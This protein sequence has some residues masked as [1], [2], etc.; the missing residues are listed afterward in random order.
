MRNLKIIAFVSIKPNS[1]LACERKIFSCAS[2]NVSKN[3]YLAIYNM[4]LK[5]GN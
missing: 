2:E 1:N 5:I 4:H 3:I